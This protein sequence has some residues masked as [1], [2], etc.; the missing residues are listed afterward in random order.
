MGLRHCAQMGEHNTPRKFRW[1]LSFSIERTGVSI[2]RSMGRTYD[3]RREMFAAFHEVR[4]K[5]TGS[6]GNGTAVAPE[7]GP[8]APVDRDMKKNHAESGSFRRRA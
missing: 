1:G 6:L 5:S 4:D 3:L 8:T 2:Q 7:S